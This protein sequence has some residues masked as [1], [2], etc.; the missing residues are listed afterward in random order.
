MQFIGN[1]APTAATDA[2]FGAAHTTVGP[3][4]TA[5]PAVQPVLQ[6]SHRSLPKRFGGESERMR[7]FIA[8]C[9]LFM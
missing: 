4:P 9:E 3:T 8:Q 7:T 2:E 6:R 1:G 5:T